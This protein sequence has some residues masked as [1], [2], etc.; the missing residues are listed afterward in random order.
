AEGNHKGEQ[1]V[2]KEFEKIHRQ[3]NKKFHDHNFQDLQIGEDIKGG[4]H[5]YFVGFASIAPVSV[6]WGKLK[7]DEFVLNLILRIKTKENA[8][9]LPTTFYNP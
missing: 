3:F 1:E 5:N 6:A 8:A 2:K 7:D 4:V 9:V